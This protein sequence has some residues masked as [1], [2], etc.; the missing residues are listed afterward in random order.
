MAALAAAGPHGVTLLSAPGAAG[1]MGPGWFLALVAP[2]MAAF[3]AVPC[4]AVLDCADAPGQA[5]AAL[6]AGLR[7]VVLAPEVPGFAEIC[8]AALESGATVL[9]AA[10]AALDMALLDL[11]RPAGQQRFAEWL[12]TTP[13]DTT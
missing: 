12:R 10:P 1:F 4:R 8:A 5:L 6:R 13:D 11:R 3:A 2:A 7:W 9:P